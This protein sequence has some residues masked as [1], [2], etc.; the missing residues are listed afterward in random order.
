MRKFLLA[1]AGL[2]LLMLLC[3]SPAWAQT[4]S[5]SDINASVDVSSSAFDVVLTPYN[6][7]ANADWL[8]A[9]G[10]DLDALQNTFENEGILLKAVDLENG[11]TLVITALKD[12]DAQTYF[13]LN[14]QDE[15]MRK[16][17]RV[18]HT[19]G[20]AY[21]VLG[22]AYSSAAWRNYGKDAMRFLVTQYTLREGG[23]LVCS[24][25][26]RRTIRNGYTITLDMQVTGRNAKEAD[27]TVLEGIM[28]TF[29][30]TK[31]LPMPELPV[32]LALTSAPP[33]ET[34]DGVF[35]IKG[36][37]ERKATVTATVFSLGS[38][39]SQ[40]YTDIA[41]GSGVFSM[42][43]TLPSQGI[44]SVTLTA[45]AEGALDATRA[46]SV[47]F[48]QGILPVSLTTYPGDVLG[49]ETVISGS[50]ISGATTKVSMTGPRDYAKTYTSQE[51]NIKLD[52]S[53][54]GTYT[55]VLSVTK[56]GLQ[57]RLFTYTATRSY[58]DVER[59]EKMKSSA[60]KIDYQNLAKTT[61]K[62]KAVK[63]TGY[64][65]GTESR[66]GE[67]VTTFALSKSGETYKQI[68]YAI[69]SEE[70]PFAVGTQAVLY[71]TASEA[72]SVL[73]EGGTIQNFPRVEVAFYE[74]VN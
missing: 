7:S 34:S 70:P 11:R 60:K 13:D 59:V 21:S 51:F 47:T 46:Y 27:N 63:L 31:V 52:T 45:H 40:T 50:T 9:Q 43:V 26:Q 14:N 28:K 1:V 37:T 35:T 23:Q 54:E 19:N 73:V 61:N 49:D 57:E 29:K 67:W 33:T 6:L 12:L 32:K 58:N 74:Q 22:Y 72:Y 68:V 30:F 16:E 65:T 64:I 69:S 71:G 25:Y 2:T 41:N 38:T 48:Q 8:N 62:G 53:A 15:D 18:S 39:G 56:K 42:K 24:G 17:Y 36:T 55:I 10:Q 4:Y 3:V 5:F 44:Y 20:S 66:G